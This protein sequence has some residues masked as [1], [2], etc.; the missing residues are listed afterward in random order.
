[1]H[2]TVKD[3]TGLN[4]GFL[5]DV[6]MTSYGAHDFQAN[7]I[8]VLARDLLSEHTLCEGV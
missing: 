2:P 1:M 8:D 5:D 4:H 7:Y 6:V 3:G